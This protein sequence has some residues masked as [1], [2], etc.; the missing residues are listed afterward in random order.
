[1]ILWDIKK[2]LFLK[3][4]TFRARTHKSGGVVVPH[5]LG[6]PKRLQ[7]RVRWDDL[8][9]QSPLK[10]TAGLIRIPQSSPFYLTAGVSSRGLPAFCQTSA[11]SCRH[12]Q[13][14]LSQSTGWHVW[15]WLSFLHRILRWNTDNYMTRVSVSHK[16]NST[17]IISL[18][19]ISSNELSLVLTYVIRID[20]FSRSVDI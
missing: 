8:I 2:Q 15:C 13:L 6:V 16:S 7:Q 19:Y 17:E 1:M 20:W 18:C 11:P 4:L 9:F 12:Q 14:R 5:S 3:D 10:N